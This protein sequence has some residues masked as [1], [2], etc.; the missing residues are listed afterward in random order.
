MEWQ[1]AKT[2]KLKADAAYE[3]K[4]WNRAVMKDT[5]AQC[6]HSPRL[7]HVKRVHACTLLGK[8][9]WSQSD[10]QT[11]SPRV[12]VRNADC[13]QVATELCK[14]TGAKV[15]MLN[16]ACPR[17][18]GGGCW[19]GC[20]AQEEHCCRCSD[21]YLQQQRAQCEYKYPLLNYDSTHG[22]SKT[23]DFTVLVHEKVTFF[24]DPR[25]YSMLPPKDWSEFGVLTAAAEKAERGQSLGPNSRRFISYLLEV[26]Q[27]QGCTHLVLSAWGCGAFRQDA[28]E[29]ARAFKRALLCV[30]K[31]NLPEVVFAITDDHNSKPPGNL[32]QFNIEFGHAHVPFTPPPRHQSPR[33]SG[34][35]TTVDN[36]SATE[37]GADTRQPSERTDDTTGAG[38]GCGT[39]LKLC[40]AIYFHIYI[41]IYI[42]HTA[43]YYRHAQHS[44]Y[45]VADSE[46]IIHQKLRK[47]FVW[48]EAEQVFQASP[49]SIYAGQFFQSSLQSMSP[50]QVFQASA[51]V[52]DLLG[53]LAWQTCL[54]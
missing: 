37:P 35:S 51:W 50:E 6:H 49:P 34:P 1:T 19:S 18:P 21:L 5:F 7:R 4:A 43:G 42:E 16:M 39:N 11:S 2:Q 14:V 36:A 17:N 12:E 27:M 29:V 13:V 41:Y 46:T 32:H 26:A 52:E 53:R 9:I 38:Q 22:S 28:A 8:E 24:K 45:E 23:P 40:L 54:V 48:P 10:V 3:R 25:D 33:A 20:N 47:E 30:K 15:Y 44:P 31:T